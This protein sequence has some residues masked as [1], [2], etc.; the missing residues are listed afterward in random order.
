MVRKNCTI[1]FLQQF[2]SKTMYGALARKDELELRHDKR[3]GWFSWD[4]SGYYCTLPHIQSGVYRQYSLHSMHGVL[5]V[6][7]GGLLHD[8]DHVDDN[9]NDSQRQLLQL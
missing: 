3:D 9:D 1:D 5:E 8:N 4:D 2:T 7:S 6:T